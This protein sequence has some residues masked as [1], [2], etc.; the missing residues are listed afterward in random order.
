M[1]NFSWQ[2]NNHI[3]FVLTIVV[4]FLISVVNTYSFIG[5]TYDN[6]YNFLCSL[7]V[8]DVLE[9]REPFKDYLYFVRYF[10]T[11]LP[12]LSVISSI[13]IGITSVKYLLGIFT[14]AV[15]FS[16]IIFLTLIYFNIPKNKKNIFHVILF[17]FLICTSYMGYFML[18]EGYFTSL[19]LFI[20]FIIY[21][22]VDFGKITLFN[23]F[24]LMIFSIFL[25]SSHP[26]VV[27]YIPLL[28]GLG[29][30]RYIET[31]NIC[32]K[33]KIFINLS[34]FLL[35]VA[36]CVNI[37]EIV[38]P[39]ADYEEYFHFMMFEDFNFINF[40]LTIFLIG[41]ISFFNIKNKKIKIISVIIA[42]VTVPYVVF[43]IQPIQG[44][45]YRMITIYIPFM[46]MLFLLIS[47]IIKMKNINLKYM[48][49]TN[50]VLLFSLLASTLSYAHKNNTFNA[51]ISDYMLKNKSISGTRFI[52]D[53]I[54]NKY[55]LYGILLFCN[56][57]PKEIKKC[58]ISITRKEWERY[59]KSC[60]RKNRFKKFGI[61]L[62]QIY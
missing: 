23:I 18:A 8:N 33:N 29:I 17:S 35:M 50:L 1:K 7:R 15:Y 16:P 21:F 6:S 31:K 44:R 52:R 25:I 36:F 14:F 43:N 54:M 59:H 56:V 27:I 19:F 12:H 57:F 28:L 61:Y 46:A 60:I 4:L 20:I 39:I 51:I 55:D 42:I 38:R 37:Y 62:K 34:F 58:T 13:H 40:M 30:F 32:L 22:Y 47:E 5:L 10:P 26:Q 48:K 24:S 49:I 45:E 3:Y 41:L 11:L 9:G 53:G 2:N